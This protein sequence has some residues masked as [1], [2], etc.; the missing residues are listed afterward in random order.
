M[1]I[2]LELI[3]GIIGSVT[4]LLGATSLFIQILKYSKE[5]PRIEAKLL[6][7]KHYY[8]KA[9]ESTTNYWLVFLIDILVKNKGDRATTVAY[10]TLD[11]KIGRKESRITSQQVARRVESND[12]VEIR[13]SL[14]SFFR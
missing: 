14:S 1:A 3:L 10:A 13:P 9:G 7:S 12:M 11:F 8:E 5:R 6:K 4:G 2:S